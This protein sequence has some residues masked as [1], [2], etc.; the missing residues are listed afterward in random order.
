MA[1]FFRK[2]IKILPGV[3]LNV[4]KTG[5]SAS[6][7]TR[8]ASVTV[9]KRGTY[10]NTGIPGTGLY[11][12]TK[13]SSS[14][15]N[16]RKKQNSVSYVSAPTTPP[17]Q[18][19]VET[20]SMVL[21][22]VTFILI[23][24]VGVLC[25]SISPYFV[26]LELPLVLF[27]LFIRPRDYSKKEKKLRDDLRKKELLDAQNEITKTNDTLKKQILQSFVDYNH[28]KDKIAEE[29]QIIQKLSQN[30]SNAKKQ[31]SLSE[32]QSILEDLKHKIK[33]CQFDATKG[34]SDTILL[35]YD[36]LCQQFSKLMQ[37]NMIW[38]VPTC[39]SD[40]YHRLR[41]ITKRLYGGFN[42]IQCNFEVPT[43]LA[44]NKRIYIY[45]TFVVSAYN[46]VNFTITPIEDVVIKFDAKVIS[47]KADYPKDAKL[48]KQTWTHVNKNGE[49][50]KRYSENP[51][52]WIFEYGEMNLFLSSGS[53]CFHFS[54]SE[55]A[56]TFVEVF[57]AYINPSS[58]TS[59]DCNEDVSNKEMSVKVP[60]SIS[61]VKALEPSDKIIEKV[62]KDILKIKKEDIEMSLM[63]CLPNDISM[64]LL[65]SGYAEISITEWKKA[66]EIWESHKAQEE[67]IQKTAANNNQGIEFEEIGDIEKAIEAYENNVSIDSDGRHAY[68]RL[69]VLYHKKGLLEE[70]IRI[71]RIASEKFPSETKYLKR[72]KKLKGEE[73]TVNL[74]TQSIVYHPRIIYGDKFEEAI[75]KIPEFDFYSKGYHNNEYYSSYYTKED[76]KEIWQIQSH[77]KELI[78]NAKTEEDYNNFTGAAVLYEQV[79]AERYWMPEPY[80]RL[81]VIYS[82]AKLKEEEKRVLQLAINHFTSLKAKRLEYVKS[83]ARKYNAEEFAEERIAHGEKITYFM[84]VFEL[85]NPYPIIDKWKERLL[86]LEKL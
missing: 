69:L 25:F 45:P 26:I 53:N 4:G 11:S 30:K 6:F 66:N 17:T 37:C 7:G 3:H 35:E 43:I 13:I 75:L 42:D 81:I 54:N 16:T 1:L 56:R 71:A 8:G 86:K 10:L 47:E 48:V 67:K 33:N 85:Y 82:K 22:V 65:C 49:P 29:E 50:N 57:Q 28:L 58:H 77:F 83:L 9:G 79:I 27:F 80:N 64:Q 24:L 68:D 36:N 40:N 20:M 61:E 74:P 63:I 34:V 38:Y 14:K 46:S 51:K 41:H 70:E 12:R 73:D 21:S 84:G 32:H 59:E 78:S 19:E 5:V 23:I 60:N 18:E 31:Q 52:I 39:T 2:R 15:S 44:D 55:S 76:L 62:D 72:L